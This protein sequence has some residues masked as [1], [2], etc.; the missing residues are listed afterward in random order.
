MYRELDIFTLEIASG[1]DGR[2]VATV[3][4][5]LTEVVISNM[6]ADTDLYL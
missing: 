2:K 1:I 6:F 3:S 5:S 4:R